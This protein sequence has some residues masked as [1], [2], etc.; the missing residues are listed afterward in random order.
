MT[1]PKRQAGVAA[2][3][4]V[5]DDRAWIE[6]LV[7]ECEPDGEPFDERISLVPCYTVEVPGIGGN[8]IF[9]GF[10]A[11][12]HVFCD[13][14]AFHK[15]H[16]VKLKTLA[17]Y[18]SLAKLLDEQPKERTGPLAMTTVKS[19]KGPRG[20]GW[21]I[22]QDFYVSKDASR[23]YFVSKDKVDFLWCM[24]A[25]P[26]APLR[27][28]EKWW[29]A[30]DKVVVRPGQGLG[31]LDLTETFI[32]PRGIVVTP[33]EKWI[34]L[35]HDAGV[36]TIDTTAQTAGW[37]R[38]TWLPALPHPDAR[39][40]LRRA[41][42]GEALY[43]IGDNHLVSLS[44]DES[45]GEL[46]PVQDEPIVSPIALALG[47]EGRHL[48]VL[49]EES[50]NVF[51]CQEHGRFKRLDQKNIK[52]AKDVAVS[53]DGDNLYIAETDAVCVWKRNHETG[54][55]TYDKV[56]SAR[57]GLLKEIDILEASPKGD[58]LIAASSTTGTMVLFARDNNGDLKSQSLSTYEAE[59]EKK[60]VAVQY[61]ASGKRVYA[62]RPTGLMSVLEFR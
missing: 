11:N 62:L 49:G 50:V 27:W 3:W 9:F 23:F 39:F 61:D 40:H 51:E 28:T 1:E 22:M 31:L 43:G 24:D 32:D 14:T 25:P 29:I 6:E 55:A 36:S 33:D 10:G 2:R 7:A 42:F 46:R 59:G 35:L 53:P 13:R 37:S 16:T 38:P 12:G 17:A 20:P 21:S 48:Y 5:V 56:A 30:R 52:S 34:V 18:E 26:P 41:A 4:T 54:I 45:S 19:I 60:L 47:P 8:S 15:K 44:L 58:T 57:P